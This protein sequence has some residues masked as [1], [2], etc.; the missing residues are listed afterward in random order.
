METESLIKALANRAEPVKR[1]PHPLPRTVGWFMVTLIYGALAAFVIGLRADLPQRLSE[2]RFVVELGAA[3]L[4]SM[5]AAAAAY[6]SGSPGRPLWE[7]FAPFP[8]LAL[9]LGTLGQGCW[10]DWMQFGDAG[11]RIVPDLVCFP[12]IVG[13]SILPGTLMLVML[14]DGAPV[15]PITTVALGTLAA[16]ALSA[17]VLRLTHVSDVSIMVLVWQIGS[18]A[19]LTGIAALLGRKLLP[20]PEVSDRIAPDD[21]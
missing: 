20:W 4:T 21:R 13:I 6:G 10:Q 19:L 1:L 18:V 2:P 16:A 9:W 17:T 7:R 8:F 14:R 15:A 3:L 11:L 12:I 5:M